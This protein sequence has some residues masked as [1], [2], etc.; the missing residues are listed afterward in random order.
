M[1][2]V[3]DSLMMQVCSEELPVKGNASSK[4][5]LHVLCTERAVYNFYTC[6][7]LPAVMLHISLLVR[8]STKYVRA[9]SLDDNGQS[10][11]EF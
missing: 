2:C 6:T 10:V 8:W 1:C 11:L 7:L 3:N 5:A 9:V 4:L